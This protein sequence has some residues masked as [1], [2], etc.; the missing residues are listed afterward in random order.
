MK[1]SIEVLH[2]HASCDDFGLLSMRGKDQ[3]ER[4][5][6][7]PADCRSAKFAK[8]YRHGQDHAPHA[9]HDWRG[10]QS[11]IS[12]RVSGLGKDFIISFLT[13]IFD[14]VHGSHHCPL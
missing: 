10:Q 13:E 9:F 3:S 14:T 5:I 12:S 11:E 7:F 4:C 2:F 6:F 1:A 8:F